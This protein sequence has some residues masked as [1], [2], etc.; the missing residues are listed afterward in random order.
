MVT[1]SESGVD[2]DLEEV[3]VKALTQKLKETLEFQDVIT[4][5]GHFA[6]LVRLGNQALAMS[7]DAWG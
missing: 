7:T 5:S 1:Y 4:E 2:I 6:A 3:T